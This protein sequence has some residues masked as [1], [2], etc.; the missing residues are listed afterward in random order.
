MA[1]NTLESKSGRKAF[2]KDDSPTKA[3]NFVAIEE[4]VKA[5]KAPSVR[6]SPG[7][8]KTGGKHADLHSSNLQHC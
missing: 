4:E 2:Q 5:V 6:K 1:V 8:G 7:T 3:S